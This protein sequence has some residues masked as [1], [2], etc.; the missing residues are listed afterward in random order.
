MRRREFLGAS[1]STLAAAA[2]RRL[3]SS[4]FRMHIADRTTTGINGRGRSIF[5]LVRH[6]NATE[7]TPNGRLY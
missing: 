2:L 6:T 3:T 1:G 5:M 4:T 7:E